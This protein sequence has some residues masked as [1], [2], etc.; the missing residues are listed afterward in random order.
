MQYWF[1]FPWLCVLDCFSFSVSLFLPYTHRSPNLMK[2]YFNKSISSGL[3]VLQACGG[4]C[5]MKS[6]PLIPVSLFSSISLHYLYMQP[7]TLWNLSLT[8]QYL[9]NFIYYKNAVKM[10]YR[11]HFTDP[12]FPDSIFPD[13]V[14]SIPFCA[15]VSAWL[16]SGF[17]VLGFSWCF[18]PPSF[19]S[20]G[21]ALVWM[22]DRSMCDR[23][24]HNALHLMVVA[25][26]Q[27][28]GRGGGQSAEWVFARVPLIDIQRA[29][30]GHCTT[31][32]I[33]SH[34]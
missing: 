30:L 12:C 18:S 10:Q 11:S 19:F 7:K 1:H 34:S 17:R 24:Y 33:H 4:K 20:V 16:P 14:F 8:H 5:S 6:I 15:T 26:R 31:I 25:G 28:G 2:P 22:H 27:A 32:P 9:L 29:L 13:P 3:H 21:V 23:L